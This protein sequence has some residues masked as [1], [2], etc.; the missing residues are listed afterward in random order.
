MGKM[1]RPGKILSHVW[2]KV[3]NA[4]SELLLGC[5]LELLYLHGPSSTGVFFKSFGHI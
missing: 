5:N 4:R 2:V 3:E 1:F